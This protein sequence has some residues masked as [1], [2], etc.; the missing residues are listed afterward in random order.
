MRSYVRHSSSVINHIK[1]LRTSGSTL[2]EIVS[3]TGL[4]KSTV[5]G[6]IQNI[7]RSEY[8]IEKIRAIRLEAQNKMAAQRRG[9]SL[10]NYT[11]LKPEKW[12]PDLV[13][14][15][16]H[17]LFDGRITRT[18]CTY[19]NRSEALVNLMEQKMRSLL[20]V[21]DHKKYITA[22]GVTRLAY[23]NVEIAFFIKKKADELFDH[24]QFAPRNEKISFLKAFFDDEGCMRFRKNNRIVR[25]YQHSIEIL[26]IVRGLLKDLGIESIVDKRFFEINIYR[27]ENIIKFQEMINFTPGLRVNGNRTN[28]V[29]KKDLE[30][31]E[32]L[33]MAVDSYL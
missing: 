23:F 17:F 6:H 19:Y 1:S 25:G 21:S 33:Q 9:K 12:S 27:K 30:K 22:E 14:L 20:R 2:T 3:K 5:L 15:I 29:W 28:S 10:K 8:L 4:S 32:I 7:P 13:N 16:A 11:F 24:I 26:E 31:R 18:S